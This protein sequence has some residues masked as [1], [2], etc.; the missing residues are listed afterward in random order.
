MTNNNRMYWTFSFDAWD[1]TISGT[2]D[3]G[4]KYDKSLLADLEQKI[5]KDTGV[6]S[7][8]CARFDETSE[9]SHL[10]THAGVEQVVSGRLIDLLIAVQK[11]YVETSGIFDPTILKALEN[12][13]YDKT[14]SDI[15]YQGIS[16]YSY[17]KRDLIVSQH[18]RRPLLREMKVNKNKRTVYIPQGMQIDLL[19]I[20]KGYWVDYVVQ[21][22]LLPYPSL[23]LSAGGDIYV[24]G[25]DE[26]KEPWKIKVQDPSEL[27]RDIG[28]FIYNKKQFGVATSGITKRAGTGGAGKWH[29][30]I[31]PRTGLPS[32]SD[33]VSATVCARSVTDADV[34]A[35]TAVIL[36]S[37][38][39]HSF[40]S[41]WPECE[42]V[43]VDVEGKVHSSNGLSFR[44]TPSIRGLG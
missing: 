7:K 9:I 34:Y 44:P 10:N 1:T 33:I 42:Y 19:G 11:A 25:T 31:D 2:V 29:H 26:K 15:A 12:V 21:T 18:I 43:F 41:S 5:K 23:W 20:A 27:S 40:L 30:I 6:Y 3:V 14:F 32:Q 22:F 38:Q 35:K 16:A 24:R 17:E 8:I 36:G 13:G 39:A 4:E 37:R 28:H